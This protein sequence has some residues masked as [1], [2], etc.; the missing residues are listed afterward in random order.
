MESEEKEGSGF[1][2]KI[3]YIANPFAGAVEKNL[4][5]TRDSCRYVVKQKATPIASH[6]IYPQF[7]KD[8]DTAERESDA[9]RNK[10]QVLSY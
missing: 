5:F 8:D 3:V 7:L 4:Q 1:M 10:N 2:R 6:L 9:G